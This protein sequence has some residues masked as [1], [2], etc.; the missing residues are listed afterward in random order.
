MKKVTGL[1]RFMC[2]TSL[3]ELPQ[4]FNNL[5]GDMTFIGSRPL[6]IKEVD[7][8]KIRKND[9]YSLALQSQD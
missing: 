3:D 8:D 2:F 9:H 6:S 1:G 5:K 4:L 7:I